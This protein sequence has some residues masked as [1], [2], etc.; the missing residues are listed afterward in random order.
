MP[1]DADD[2][3]QGPVTTTL[4][5]PIRKKISVD[6]RFCWWHEWHISNVCSGWK[7]TTLQATVQVLTQSHKANIYWFSCTDK[8]HCKHWFFLKM[9]LF[10]FVCER[11]KPAHTVC[12][13]KGQ[14]TPPR[15]PDVPY[16]LPSERHWPEATF[17]LS[18]PLRQTYWRNKLCGRHIVLACLVKFKSARICITQFTKVK[19]KYWNPSDD[20]DISARLFPSLV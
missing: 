7:W 14:S 11:N 16:P 3:P 12:D 5:T 13:Y 8:R 15:R 4:V 20:S 1:R 9:W 6:R 19:Y 17:L 10:H 18:Q 2:R